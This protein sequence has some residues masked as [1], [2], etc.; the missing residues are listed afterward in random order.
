MSKVINIEVSYNSNSSS[1]KDSSKGSNQLGFT[2]KKGKNEERKTTWKIK[3][4]E[5][6]SQ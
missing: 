2:E 1:M 6:K 5:K 4:P 3:V